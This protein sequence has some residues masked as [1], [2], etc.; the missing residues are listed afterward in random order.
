LAELFPKYF[1]NGSAWCDVKRKAKADGK[2]SGSR[3]GQNRERRIRKQVRDLMAGG[4]NEDLIADELGLGKTTLRRQYIRPLTQ[5]RQ[6][7]RQRR[8]AEQLSN[9]EALLYRACMVGFDDPKWTRPD[10][11]C[12]LHGDM[13]REEAEADFALR[14]ARMRG[15][16]KGG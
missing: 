1:A 2:A 11:R 14:L 6:A 15:E 13:T 16:E 7:R 8:K 3:Q 5:G 12:R 4:A 10:G 9:K